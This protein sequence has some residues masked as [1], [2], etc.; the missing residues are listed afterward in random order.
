MNHFLF[1]TL[2]K[3]QSVLVALLIIAPLS[4]FSQTNVNTDFYS[5][6]KDTLSGNFAFKADTNGTPA[7]VTAWQYIK[8]TD[9]KKYI[10]VDT[11]Y[12]FIYENQKATERSFSSNNLATAFS[13]SLSHFYFDNRKDYQFVF[14]ESFNLLFTE[15]EDISCLKTSRPLTLLSFSSSGKTEEQLRVQHYHTIKNDLLVGFDF[16]LGGITEPRLNKHEEGAR[17]FNAYVDYFGTRYRSQFN[18]LFGRLNR[19]ENGGFIDGELD[20]E[21][22]SSERYATTWL[23]NARS[24]QRYS[25]L[26]IKQEFNLGREQII[27]DSANYEV[28]PYTLSTGFDISHIT[29]KR[30]YNDTLLNTYYYKNLI[31]SLDTLSINDSARL[32]QS[33]I[34][35]FASF[36]PKLNE[37]SRIKIK[38]GAGLDIENYIH[39][40]LL[41]MNDNQSHISSY[42]YGSAGFTLNKFELF[43]DV[44]KYYAGRKSNQFNIRF[45]GI[46]QKSDSIGIKRLQASVNM[47]VVP[48]GLPLQ[49]Y[50]SKAVNWEN[51]FENQV[52]TY[53]DI[54][55]INSKWGL[56]AKAALE[57]SDNTIYFDS[58]A[59]PQQFIKPVGIFG[60][61][62]EKD[63]RLKFIGMTN[64]ISVQQSTNQ[65]VVPLPAFTT[66]NSFY[67]Y[68]PVFQHNLILKIGGEILYYSP[69]KAQSFDPV[70]G[71]FFV[72]NEKSF[73][74]IPYSN[75]FVNMKFRRMGFFLKMAN[76]SN[77]FNNEFRYHSDGYPLYST[78][79]VFGL[80]WHF[81][82]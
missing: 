10:V 50:T 27:K 69:Y 33:D 39:T 17:F 70:T 2:L 53:A 79:L 63:S 61:K 49:N 78:H 59:T 5:D 4:V 67:I 24:L 64:K 13:P 36:S 44:K 14:S 12:R 72:Q 46:T 26:F 47:D 11:V 38:A 32:N 43:G 21:K 30:F 71:M 23:S 16:H 81:Y 6:T 45:V 1:K 62:V 40:D 57:L 31:S 60:L 77:V 51:T 55:Y 37:S 41:H 73:G 19:V 18:I 48:A 66:S 8:G 74:G 25:K 7:N 80:K 52:K 15:F 82:N 29:N 54:S 76:F 75:L 65:S 58:A 35:G 34:M 3:G 68:A 9:I 28:V 56:K 42:L 22:S 20:P